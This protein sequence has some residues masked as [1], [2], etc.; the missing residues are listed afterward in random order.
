[1]TTRDGESFNDSPEARD[2]LTHELVVELSKPFGISVE[3]STTAAE[4]FWLTF[5]SIQVFLHPIE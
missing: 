1:M 5:G 2:S 3:V 4:T